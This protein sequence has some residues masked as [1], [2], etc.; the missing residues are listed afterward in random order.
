MPPVVQ[1]RTPAPPAPAARKQN[2]S[3]TSS[4]PKFDATNFRQELVRQRK[5]KA[6]KAKPRE[7]SE[8]AKSSPAKL[9]RVH[10]ARKGRQEKSAKGE[11]G[12]GAADPAGAVAQGG[13]TDLARAQELAPEIGSDGG[14]ETS[15]VDE[16][17][18]T[19]SDESSDEA[20]AGVAASVRTNDSAPPARS[21]PAGGD[22]D[23]SA[24]GVSALAATAVDAGAVA[25]KTAGAVK[26]D[27]GAGPQAPQID[28]TEVAK[29]SPAKPTSP[30]PAQ[31]AG[32]KAP[33]TGGAFGQA[34][35]GSSRPASEEGDP[36][37]QESGD[38]AAGGRSASSAGWMQDL[39]A[40]TG[41]FSEAMA[42]ADSSA[43]PH[44]GRAETT[45][46]SAS[47]MVDLSPKPAGPAG[48]HA[49]PAVADAL[50]PEARFAAANH[51][52]IVKG[53][54]AEVLP[55]GGTMR[56]RLD[57]PQLGALQVTVHVRDGVVTASFET[58][59][60]EATRLLGHS[61]NQ[62]KAVLE[63]HGVG[64]D[65]LQV[66]QAPRDEH[67][68]APRDDGSR[69]QGQTP[70]E[71]EQAARQEQQRKEMLRKMWR[72]LS[73]GADPLDVTV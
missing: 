31:D 23:H 64:V 10:K 8:A 45:D 69:H 19:R 33:P 48:P 56:I 9:S 20:A 38:N 63:S 2:A 44:A 47:S 57:P 30:R 12:S 11:A 70:Y 50:P 51:E 59:N 13:S 61:L 17:V 21:E 73:G 35:A 41:E 62:L 37:G 68:N 55:N 36:G 39:E 15:V 6:E 3:A 24:R 65:K 49:V 60:D 67:A 4:E 7:T 66:Q 32:A 43:A 42:Q 16:V 71:Q 5:A 46:P 18:E 1:H 72:R 34:L 26:D 14:A 28:E 40:A 52:N 25:E 53:M 54:H 58:S 22:N 29:D 27:A